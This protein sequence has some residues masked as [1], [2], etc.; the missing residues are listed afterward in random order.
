MTSID[1]GPGGFGIDG[2]TYTYDIGVPEA[3]GGPQGQR[4]EFIDVSPGYVDGSGKPKDLTKKTKSTLADFLSNATSG[5]GA[6]PANAYPVDAGLNDAST[7]TKTGLPT[8]QTPGATGPS[9]SR[10][11]APG[12]SNLNALSNRFTSLVGFHKGKSD[13]AGVD[14][15]E[16]LPG[17][18]GNATYVS[19]EG[20]LTGIPSSQKQVDGHADTTGV[21]GSYL[22]DVL[23][24]NRFS[25]ADSAYTVVTAGSGRNPTLS[26][27]K[28]LGTYEASVPGIT[29]AQA[30]AI[31]PLLTLRAAQELGSAARGSDPGS[32]ASQASARLPGPSQLGVTKVNVSVL[33]AMDALISVSAAPDLT[34]PSLSD[35][36]STSWG[37]LNNVD[38]PFSGTDAVGMTLLS[39]ALVAGIEVVI[40][41]VSA[42]LGAVT[43]Q[44]K[45]PTHD[46]Q[47]RYGLGEYYAGEKRLGKA[48]APGLA[49]TLNAIGTSNIGGLLGIQP[50]NHP[51]NQALSVG[52]NAFFGLPAEGGFGRQLVGSLASGIDSPGFNVVMARAILRGSVVI[53]EQA[54]K[55]KGNPVNAAAQ[56]LAL[57]DV[58]RSSKVVAACNVFASLGDALLS[59]SKEW[60]DPDTVG[61]RRVS[62]VDNIDN[63]LGTAV[64]KNRLKGSLKLAWSSNRAPAQLL[65]PS[66]IIG[67]NITATG[68]GQYDSMLGARVDP[69]SRISARILKSSPRIDAD[70]AAAFEATLDA[71]YVPFSFHDIRTNEIVS[72]HAFLASL[73]DEYTATYDKAEGY[74]RVE[75]VRT[76]RGTERKVGM[77]FYVLATSLQDFDEMWV[78]INKLVTL[79]YPQYTKG[80]EL[81][82]SDGA[83]RFTQPF[84]QLVGASPLV[85]IRLGDLLK[86][87]YSRF[88]LARLFGLGNDG[89]TLNGAKDASTSVDDNDL[90]RYTRALESVMAHP[91]GET[92]VVAPGTY[93]YV[94]GV[95]GVG[96][97]GSIVPPLAGLPTYKFAPTFS[98]QL[99]PSG[100]LIVK[101]TRIDPTGPTDVASVKAG[102]ARMICEVI[103]NDDPS[104]R[105]TFSRSLTAAAIEFGSEARPLQK[106]LGGTY[107]VPV[108]A[109]TATRKSRQK[110]VS[111][112]ALGG[113]NDAF[114]TE[115]SRFMDPGG[116]CPNAVAKSF[117]DTG[118]K[119][120]AGFIETIGFDWYD[121]VTWEV[122]PD[123]TAPKLCKVTLSFSPI[124]DIAPGIDHFG[125][126]RAPLYPVGL[127]AQQP[128]ASRARR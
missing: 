60:I 97:M 125:F 2:K 37:S 79:V 115:I 105:T 32:A 28:R 12:A 19:E 117:K 22:S 84:S 55:I 83:Y 112:L 16:L 46:A 61:N 110:I 38:D 103:L 7:T 109:L 45:K 78:K 39:I 75:P 20:S 41:V 71:E 93:P 116:P 35:V 66:N 91:N 113:N 1:T 99:A 104:Y 10:A 31:G 90:D 81:S 123:R 34:P 53:T 24:A 108:T 52:A 21:V 30:A 23:R 89:F 92:Y 95:T 64:G 18:P 101:A 68:L 33:N 54:K 111:R 50:T 107:S 36:G 40:D 70:T 106:F 9:N 82:S 15:N 122:M 73:T 127:M 29:P 13:A 98:P 94:D 74:G 76:Y 85:R 59:L 100:M 120:L 86:S 5:K 80:I 118:G 102:N 26:R 72:F 124:H 87:N 51:F 121:K 65:M 48:S 14:G 77:S 56:A 69:Q 57:M 44:A 25:G 62:R 6:S 47:G 128:D 17:V 96:L 3:D 4:I 126:N 42:M 43:S 58:I 88:S 114:S 49:G 67:P 119:G 27:Q 63:L 11:F 8:V